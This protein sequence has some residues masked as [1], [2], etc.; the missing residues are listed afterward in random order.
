MKVI[1]N[2]FVPTFL[3]ILDAVFVFISLS[4]LLEMPGNRRL[5]RRYKTREK[6]NKKKGDK[7][8]LFL[9]ITVILVINLIY[10][11]T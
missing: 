5:L 10:F 2:V 3:L 6:E 4:K 8:I 11:Y 9:L 1:F 7:L